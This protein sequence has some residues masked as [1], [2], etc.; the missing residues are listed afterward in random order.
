[1]TDLSL[2]VTGSAAAVPV[3]SN[4]TFTVRV[5]NA[6]PAG[7][8][9]VAV[10]DQLPSGLTFVS[11]APTQGTYTSA[12][13]LWSVGSLAAGASATVQ[14]VARVATT[15]QK[16][17]T[18][19]VSAASP[20][21]VDSTPGNGVPGEDDQASVTV[22]GTATCAASTATRTADY[23]SWITT[24]WS[25]T[26]FG[27]DAILK[28]R[29]KASA[30]ARTLVH[31]ALPSLPAGC[32]VASAK[33]RMYV[34]SAVGTRTLRAV[35]LAGAWTETGV[36]WRNQPTT[37]GTAATVPAVKGWVEWTV[38]SQ[39]AGL[40][41]DGNH[42]LQIRDATEGAAG[43]E[44]RLHSRENTSKPTLTVTFGAA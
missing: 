11:A 2:T 13:G 5:A 24:S 16:T 28:V 21:D 44:Q 35:R 9:G 37:T 25:T 12:T 7:A 22:N 19:Q 31:F 34:S 23:D 41:T 33:L 15:G 10:T 6:G 43:Y 26:N 42:G 18:A 1:M 36:T 17:N 8:T 30:D 29:S 14:I 27:G 20:A 4:V 40:Y 38:T 39:V 3:G 32:K